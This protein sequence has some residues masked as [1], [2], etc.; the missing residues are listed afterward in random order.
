MEHTVFSMSLRVT[1]NSHNSVKQD[2]YYLVDGDILAQRG[3]T[4]LGTLFI[5]CWY[6]FEGS[7]GNTVLSVNDFKCL[8]QQCC[9]GCISI[10]VLQVR[11]QE[12][13]VVK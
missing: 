2:Y 13:V 9:E 10:S 8:L 6:H 1:H 3:H 12:S 11:L 7:V 5:S 4:S